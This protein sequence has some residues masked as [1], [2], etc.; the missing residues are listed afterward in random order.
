M[1]YRTVST[2][3]EEEERGKFSFA[4]MSKNLDDARMRSE[5]EKKI[6]FG[7]L[8]I[9]IAFTSPSITIEPSFRY[10]DSIALVTREHKKLFLV[11][12]TAVNAVELR[13]CGIAD[14]ADE[15]EFFE[16]AVVAG[17][18]FERLST[19]YTWHGKLTMR[20]NSGVYELESSV[21]DHRAKHH[22]AIDIVRLDPFAL[23]E[24]I[25]ILRSF[26]T[27]GGWWRRKN[28]GTGVC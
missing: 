26:G 7:R 17:D 1:R 20:C 6:V 2:P 22:R 8:P 18:A 19:V 28:L 12:Y 27:Q 23:R 14:L 25:T 10:T 5:A 11:P 15:L 4:R 9:T 13:I 24:L 16:G 3:T 21:H